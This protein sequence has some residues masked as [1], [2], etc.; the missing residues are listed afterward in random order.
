MGTLAV[1]LSACVTLRL[2]MPSSVRTL[3]SLS[4][5]ATYIIRFLPPSKSQRLFTYSSFPFVQRH[6]NRGCDSVFGVFRERTTS[7]TGH[8]TTGTNHWSLR[9]RAEE[10]EEA[11]KGSKVTAEV[12]AGRGHEV[13]LSRH[14]T[15]RTSTDS[16]RRTSRSRP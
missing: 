15:G 5:G 1:G 3:L 16:F 6:V 9:R 8:P 4:K 10:T 13:P 12:I 14:V 11:S 7:D 2:G